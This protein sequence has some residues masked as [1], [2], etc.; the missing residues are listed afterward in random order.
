MAQRERKSSQE[1]ERVQQCGP[2]DCRDE[3]TEPRIKQNARLRRF[4]LIRSIDQ[5]AIPSS[6]GNPH[7]VRTQPLDSP[8]LSANE[9]NAW[10]GIL[11]QKV[12]D[13][14]GAPEREGESISS[15][16]AAVRFWTATPGTRLDAEV[17][18]P[19][20]GAASVDPFYRVV[21]SLCKPGWLL[22]VCA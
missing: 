5:L 1:P 13:T 9:A 20:T 6:H 2:C 15:F 18:K 17:S 7:D 19:A 4:L 22:Y 10:R 12:D 8:K 14:H 3:S 21:T 16:E 11:I